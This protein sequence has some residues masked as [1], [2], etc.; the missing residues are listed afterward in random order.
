M[1]AL[2]DKQA[3]SARNGREITD[4]GT[5]RGQAPVPAPPRARR[6]WGLFAAMVALVA[7]GALG[8]V[9]LHAAT[10]RCAD[11]G[12]GAGPRSSAAV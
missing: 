1:T 5:G 2:T 6:R 4:A 9:W 3:R 7:V 12:G 10:T 11:G 8:N